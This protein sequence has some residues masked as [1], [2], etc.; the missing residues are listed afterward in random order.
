MATYLFV[1]LWRFI[2]RSLSFSLS[3]PQLFPPYSTLLHS[4]SLHLT[5]TTTLF[6]LF[7]VGGGI[8][9]SV[10]LNLVKSLVAQCCTCR[11]VR[12]FNFVPFR[13]YSTSSSIFC[14]LVFVFGVALQGL[15]N[16][17]RK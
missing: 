9:S 2:T 12:N 16:K 17:K 13:R 5:S 11:I 10:V 1:R 4:T 8:Y 3:T 6:L 15:L 14:S 7:D